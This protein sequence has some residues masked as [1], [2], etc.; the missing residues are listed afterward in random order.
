MVTQQ[1][2]TDSADQRC[3]HQSMRRVERLKT[4]LRLPD[5]ASEFRYVSSDSASEMTGEPIGLKRT[6]HQ[7]C[8]AILYTFLSS[9]FAFFVTPLHP[10]CCP[11]HASWPSWPLFPPHPRSPSRKPPRTSL[12]PHARNPTSTLRSSF[13]P[14]ITPISPPRR[15]T[16]PM[17]SQPKLWPRWRRT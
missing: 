2:C 3:V 13:P 8:H 16:L 17:D 15:W 10:P 14:T 4:G 1:R 7:R 6:T 12:P 5:A 9:S 11:N